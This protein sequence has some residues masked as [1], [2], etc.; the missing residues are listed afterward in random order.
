MLTCH[1]ADNEAQ[2]F[3]QFSLD[4][5]KSSDPH[6]K[7]EK[8]AFKTKNETKQLQLINPDT[9][10]KSFEIKKEIKQLELIKDIQAELNMILV[11][12]HDQLKIWTEMEDIMR[13]SRMWSRP[14]TKKPPMIPCIENTSRMYQQA[15]RVC[16][17]VS[18]NNLI[19]NIRIKRLQL[20]DLL[21]LKQKQANVAE[22]RSQRHQAEETAR[23]GKAILLFTVITIIFVS[24]IIGCLITGNK[25]S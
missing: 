12:F 17:A 7:A 22:A 2:L 25:A 15:E 14:S 9:N 1:K 5:N 19:K 6:T 18:T 8:S 11:L 13:F 4:L 10:E 24:N 23:Q 20:Q 16:K 21:D 3:R